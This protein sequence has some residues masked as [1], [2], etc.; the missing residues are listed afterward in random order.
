MFTSR[1][2]IA[3]VVLLMVSAVSLIAPASALPTTVPGKP[4]TSI[5]RGPLN[6]NTDGRAQESKTSHRLIVELSSDSLVNWTPSGPA[7]PAATGRPD[8]N[9]P[10]AQAYITQL[11][12]EQAAFVRSM[13]TALPGAR[14]NTFRNERG[15]NEAAT[16]QVVFNGLS[17][18]PGR[19]NREQARQALL[20][21]PNVKNVYLDYAYATTLYSSTDL[22]NAPALWNNA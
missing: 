7:T 22:I 9:S 6:P 11:R 14:V 15:V 17:V 21:L 4:R 2:R 20:K 5:P 13:N 19:N 8:V 1:L 18:D 10:A 12:R 3:A 16:Y